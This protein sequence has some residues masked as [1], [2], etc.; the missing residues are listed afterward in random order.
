MS[1]KKFLCNFKVTIP[2]AHYNNCELQFKTCSLSYSP[3]FTPLDL[4]Q[5]LFPLWSHRTY[6]LSSLLVLSFPWMTSVT[7]LIIFVISNQLA[8]TAYK[9]TSCI[10][11]EVLQFALSFFYFGN[12][13][14]LVCS[15]LLS[16][17][18]PILQFL[19]PVIKK[20]SLITIILPS[21]LTQS[22]GVSPLASP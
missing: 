21:L 14:T 10:R 1:Q 6:I 17:W 8:L 11:Y 22:L 5:Q 3:L 18:V 12:P 20:L 9:V 13:W 15:L 7:H 2:V 16:K 4:V 19:N